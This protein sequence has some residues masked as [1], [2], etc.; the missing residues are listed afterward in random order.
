MITTIP[1]DFITLD[2]VKDH[3]NKTSTAD[4]AELA[5][6]ISAAQRMIIDRVGQVSQVTA[7]EDLNTFGDAVILSHRPIITV[8]TVEKLPGLD[9]V[10]QADEATD[11]AGWFLENPEGVLK[12]TRT[13]PDRV[14]VTYEPGRDPVPGNI[15]MAGLELV[16]HLWQSSQHF[17]P[18]AGRPNLELDTT[19]IPG[20]NYAL[21][22][23]VRELLGLGKSPTDRPLVG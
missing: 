14:R 9:P 3:L 8:T 4:D 15:T 21:P 11:V 16:A 18:S 2:Q 23:R 6:F 5:V 17:R 1:A 12:H 20:V 10:P 7:V 19:V 22:I 13:F